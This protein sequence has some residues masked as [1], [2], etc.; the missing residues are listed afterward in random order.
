VRQVG[1]GMYTYLPMGWRVLQ[2]VMGIVR[3]EMNTIG[4]EM[5]MPVLNPAELWERTDRYKIEALFKLK[6]PS[7]RP[8]VLA[9]SHEECGT[10]HASA[11]RRWSGAVP[12]IGYH[13][14]PKGGD[15]R[16]P[17]AAIPRPR[18]FIMKASYSS[19]RDEAGRDESYDRH[20]PV[21]KRILERCGLESWM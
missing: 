20:I 15:E 11:I 7:E 12:K 17:K 8:Y 3:E 18:E 19:A 13:T 9:L 10:V 5:L 4:D 16:G 1:S 2:R 21:Y 6:D 14:K